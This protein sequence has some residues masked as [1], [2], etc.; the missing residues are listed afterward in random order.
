MDGSP[1]SQ[2][3][4][5]SCHS[6]VAM[7]TG[8]DRSFEHSNEVEGTSMETNTNAAASLLQSEVLKEDR[9]RVDTVLPG[10]EVLVGDVGGIQRRGLFLC[11]A[12]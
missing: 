2:F 8:T 4:G 6:D 5:L 12:G 11:H 10:S 7:L 3:E 1:L 9:F